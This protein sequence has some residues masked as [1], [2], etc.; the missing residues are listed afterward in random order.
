MQPTDP[1]DEDGAKQSY[2]IGAR[3]QFKRYP[4]PKTIEEL[5]ALDAPM[6]R[7]VDPNGHC[8]ILGKIIEWSPI[9]FIVADSALG[10]VT[11]QKVKKSRVH[12]E[13][14]DRCWNQH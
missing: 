9:Y 5:T 7:M 8:V 14:C 11:T 12:F 10:R 3:I 6:A 2:P 1:P 4:V 13:P